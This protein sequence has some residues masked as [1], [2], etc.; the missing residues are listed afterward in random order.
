MTDPAPRVLVVDDETQM[1]SIV[2]FAL[3]TQGFVPS[4]ARNAE[5]AWRMLCDERFDLV[6]LDVMLPG[7]S[8]IQLTERIRATSD[9]PVVL[10]TARGEEEDRLRGL[11][12]GADDYLTK[13]FSPRELALRAAAIIRR[14]RSRAPEQDVLVNGPL[15]IDRG[16]RQ[17][18]LDG[19]PLRLSGVE[20]ELLV[21][22]AVRAGEPV[23]WRQLLN[24]VW[25]TAVL[26]GGRD[27]VKT[28]AYRLRHAIGPTADDLIVTV[29]GVGYLMPRLGAGSD[30]D[31]RPP[32]P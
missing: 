5:Q 31:A 29:R 26:A 20:Y 21:A 24:E 2:S 3:E 30:P 6:V 19:V 8:G 12:A 7:A 18:Q 17:A 14:T 22:L 32:Q 13:P 1:V 25:H 15:R 27:M 10:L 28:A 9:T 4:V 11:L 23:E 16:R